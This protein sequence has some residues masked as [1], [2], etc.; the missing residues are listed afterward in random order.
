M[1]NIETVKEKLKLNNVRD[2]N[3]KA[4]ISSKDKKVFKK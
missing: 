4:N 1:V 3:F 2:Y